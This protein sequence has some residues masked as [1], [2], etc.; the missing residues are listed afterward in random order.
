MTME[1][2]RSPLA[3][4]HIYTPPLLPAHLSGAYGLKTIVGFPTNEDIKAIH[5]AIGAVDAG[6]RVPHLY[7]P[8][9]S[10]RLSQHL[11]SVQMAVYRKSYP[12]DLFPDNTYTPPQLPAHIPITLEPIVGVPSKQQLKSAQDAMRVSESPLSDP[13]L[14][15]QLSQHLF[16]LQ[17]AR[18]IQDSTFGQFTPKSEVSRRVSQESQEDSTIHND[19]ANTQLPSESVCE[20]VVPRPSMTEPTQSGC[21]CSTTPEIKEQGETMMDIKKIMIESKGVLENMNRVLTAVQ[22]NQ[23]VVGEWSNHNY[24]H[25]NPVNEQGVTATECGLPQFRFSYYRGQYWTHLP[26]LD[27][28]RYLK[29]FGI[30]T[31]LL[32]GGESPRIKNGQESEAKTVLFKHMGMVYIY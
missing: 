32:E 13:D 5:A 7:D 15:M 22:R 25:V 4:E 8:D 24:A 28:A 19:H 12:L 14:N 31:H 27:L 26:A 16:N 20:V 3:N 10:L 9:L 29:F 11:F 6:A 17:F 23:I 18:Y 21:Q 2:L 30:G 1:A